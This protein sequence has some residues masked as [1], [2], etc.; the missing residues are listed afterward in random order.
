MTNPLKKIIKNRIII[1]NRLRLLNKLITNKGLPKHFYE[2][3]RYLI[4]QHADPETLEITQEIELIR[5]DIAKQGDKKVKILYSPQPHSAGE[6]VTEDLRPPPGQILEFTMAKVAHLGKNRIWGT[7]L[8]LL[9]NAGQAKTILELGS[10]V[11]ISGCYL[12]KSKVCQSFITIEGSAELAQLADQ[13]LSKINQ[14]YRVINKLFDDALDEILP[15]LDTEID[16]AFVDGHHEKIATIHYYQRIMPKLADNAIVVFDDV[17]WSYDMR[18]AWEILSKREEFEHS[19]DLGIVGVC[20]F[21]K[22][23]KIS[24]NH[25]WDLQPL[26]GPV[27]GKTKIGN[28]H[29]WKRSS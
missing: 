6:V 19:M 14:K 11:G 28:P 29:G 27:M 25:Y 8:Y 21:R 13:S 1:P 7:C 26:V 3:L 23:G 5:Q 22:K 4:S 15:Q 24:K 16:F 17:S 18:E 12:A 20:I 10:C 9:A 2:P